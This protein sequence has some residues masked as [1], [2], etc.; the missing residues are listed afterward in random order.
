MTDKDIIKALEC[1][2]QADCDRCDECPYKEVERC[3]DRMQKDAAFLIRVQQAEIERL[4]AEVDKQYEQA[5]ADILGNMA[6]G[7]TSCHW[8]IAEHKK[9]AVKTFVERIKARAYTSE[10]EWSHCEHPMVVEVG[11]IDECV[12]EMEG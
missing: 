7:G 2:F 4:T 6:D 8:C 3:I 5:Q 12:A 9:N 1:C 11:D 10:R